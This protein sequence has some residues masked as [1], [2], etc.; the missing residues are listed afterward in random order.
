MFSY[1]IKHSNT[2]LNLS[3]QPGVSCR[4]VWST[5][6]LSKFV[7]KRKSAFTTRYL[8]DHQKSLIRSLHRAGS[9]VEGNL[10]SNSSIKSTITPAFTYNN[11]SSMFWLMIN[12]WVAYHRCT[13]R[14]FVVCNK[15]AHLRI[16]T[17]FGIMLEGIASSILEKLLGDYVSGLDAKNLKF[18]LSGELELSNLHLKPSALEGLG[19]PMKVVV[20]FL[21]KLYIRIPWSSLGSKPAVIRIERLFVLAKP[22]TTDTVHTLLYLLFAHSF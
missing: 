8:V 16:T 5:N 21:K 12:T 6:S 3:K 7:I 18:S 19:L 4:L 11:A 13:T 17:V 22:S 10:N 15:R 20:G 1:S 14:L 9:G 2:N